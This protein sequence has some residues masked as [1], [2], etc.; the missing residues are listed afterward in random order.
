MAWH[1]GR[2]AF[3]VLAISIIAEPGLAAP[4]LT[5]T[6]N[7]GGHPKVVRQ[8]SGTGFS[9]N[10]AVDV[11]FDT[12]DKFLAV[13]DGSGA[14]ANHELDIPKDAL[15]G[16]HWI[17][18]V[19][20]KTGDA[21]QKSFLV[22]T[23]WLQYGF[24]VRGRGRNPYE[25]VIDKSNVG[26]LDVAWSHAT[27]DQIYS[28]PAYQTGT[29]YV[30]SLDHKLYALDSTTGAV[31]WT[32]NTGGSLYSSPAVANG[33]VYV[34]SSDGHLH[35]FNA[36][37]GAP[38]WSAATGG[39]VT[40]SPVAVGNTVYFGSGD[41]SVYAV[42]ATNG[43]KI[44]STPTG[45]VIEHS[46]PAVVNNVVYIGSTDGKLYALN[47]ST[48]AILWSYTTGGA[49]FESPAVANGVV[50]FGS[51]DHTVYAV[52]ANTGSTVWTY[53][54]GNLVAASPAVVN[55]TVFIGSDDET[56]YALNADT[57]AVR[58]MSAAGG[59]FAINSV[60]IAN[61]VGYVGTYED[62]QLRAFDLTDGTVLWSAHASAQ[63]DT[64][65]T[66]ADGTL[67][68]GSW[69]HNIY[70]YALDAGNNAAYRRN[71][72]PPSYASLHPDFRL[73]PMK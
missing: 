14:F 56:L 28:A 58:W 30:G 26:T 13:T 40:A 51:F 37:T 44:W 11:Y 22:T 49:V 19:G 21:V 41:D 35:A 63:F 47:A 20:R 48:G 64:R 16:T 24:E 32:A 50:Y 4:A 67:Y 10:E 52:D 8:I 7:S 71:R 60:S 70:A 68:A 39:P 34:G 12:S 27:G 17:T 3:C 57:G 66:I 54:T 2:I 25:N 46:A 53:T 55:N 5:M 33:N 15:P 62:G 72:T 61:G 43:H 38:V 1:H 65:P 9:A 36:A 6:P 42:N 29:L 59:E 69:D 73:K 23:S 31:K 18:A 45:A